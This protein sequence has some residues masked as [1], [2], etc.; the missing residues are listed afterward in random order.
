M[1]QPSNVSD[2]ASSPQL[3]SFDD[4]PYLVTYIVPA[5][6]HIILLPAD[7]AVTWLS[8]FLVRQVRFNGLRSCLV[9]GANDCVYYSGADGDNLYRD[10][11]VPIPKASLWTAG[12]LAPAEAFEETD[13]L[14]RRRARLDTFLGEDTQHGFMLGDVT[15]GGR[16][17]TPTELAD[18][19][20][21]PGESVPRGL[22]R[23]P[24]C[25]EYRGKCLDPDPN[26]H[27]W[28]MPVHCLC[29]ANNLCA[30]CG[31][32]L[33]DRKLNGNSYDPGDGR[34]WHLPAFTAL[35]HSC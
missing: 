32:K 28:V 13:E 22:V 34:I 33:S 21:R 24:S 9:T 20:Q 8:E 5:L 26:F 14:R 3:R 23:C 15:K 35:T 6:F 7:M 11:N 1:S 27:G 4:Y 18:L 10:P 31:A 19:G 12:G 17:A 29:E 30:A 25:G 16:S 2:T